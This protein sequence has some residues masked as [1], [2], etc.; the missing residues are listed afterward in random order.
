MGKGERRGGPGWTDG[1]GGES[2][3]KGR[4]EMVDGTVARERAGMATSQ[5]CSRARRDNTTAAISKIRSRCS[6]RQRPPSPLRAPTESIHAPSK[7]VSDT[8]ALKDGE[9]LTIKIGGKG[10]V[11]KN[12]A[13]NSNSNSGGLGGVPLLPPPPGGRK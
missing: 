2:L 4:E 10:G 13:Q 3:G 6:R 5:Q 12:K 7:A 1:N 8:F 9:T 11:N